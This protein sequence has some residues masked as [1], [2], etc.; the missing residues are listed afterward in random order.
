[1]C[2]YSLN[3]SH[4]CLPWL[5]ARTLSQDTCGR[6]AGSRAGHILPTTSPSRKAW[7]RY[8]RAAEVETSAV[9]FAA[10]HSCTSR[11]S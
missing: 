10:H 5:L 4:L 1:M 3:G 8:E 9:T 2:S 11:I 7:D 6:V